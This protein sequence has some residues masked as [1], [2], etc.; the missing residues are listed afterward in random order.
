[1]QNSIRKMTVSAICVALMCI[2]S[3]ISFPLGQISLSLQL[4]AVYFSLYYQGPLYG[5][6]SVVV[7]LVLGAIGVPVFSLFGG[8]ISAF[9]G[10]S[11]GFLF[12][13]IFMLLVY[14]LALFLF[15]NKRSGKIIATVVALL[16]LYLCGSL[17]YSLVY[18][19]GVYALGQSLLVTVL[20]FILPD[21][22]KIIL[23]FF[24]NNRLSKA[25]K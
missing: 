19:G 12:G 8:G 11:G 1:M 14:S 25:K 22:V 20:P 13:F 2:C 3:F 15:R 4:F 23:A 10:P 24:I 16:T 6:V 21:I 9:V 18:L 17:Y 7:Y 5:S